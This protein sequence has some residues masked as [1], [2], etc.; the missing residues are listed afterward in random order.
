M[1]D[2]LG[3]H[4]I[5]ALSI[6][7]TDPRYGPMRDVL[8]TALSDLRMVI[9]SVEPVDGDLA[10]VLAMT[11][12]RCARRVAQAG[13]QF[14]WNVGDL[15]TMPQLDPDHVLQILRILDEAITNVIRHAQ[16]SRVAVRAWPIHEPGGDPGPVRI[17]VEIGDDGQ[18]FANRDPA[19]PAP[20]P[21]ASGG[22]GL[23]N[24]QQRAAAIGAALQVTSSR[25]GTVVRLVLDVPA[26]DPAPRA[27]EPLI[28]RDGPAGLSGGGPIPL[29]PGGV[30]A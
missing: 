5:H 16:A 21:V 9:D 17:C 28:A 11:R 26:E 29:S 2:G 10:A 30:S 14:D 15:P 1:H 27:P 4:L 6:A 8:R 25:D 12:S 24:M 22:R 23:R 3:G 13:L 19:T 20:E 18:G 7:E